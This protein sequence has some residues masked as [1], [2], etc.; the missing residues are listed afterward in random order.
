MAIKRHKRGG[1]VYLA[2]YKSVRVGKKVISKFIRYIGP[3]DKQNDIDK[4][5]KKVLDRLQL[6]RSYR[7]GDVR[8][9][10]SIAKD[11]G[12][13]EIIDS[14][15]CSK[16]S[17]EGPSP[18][19]LLTAW[20]INR[21]IDPESATKLER[22]IPTTELPILLDLPE[23]VFTK[24]AF[25][26]A[27]DFVCSKSEDVDLILDQTPELDKS[28]YEKWRKY[29]PLSD[30]QRE[31]I[32]YDMTTLLF[33]G[34][35]CPL[36]ELGYN[37]DRIR[38][39]QVNLALLVSGWDKF[40][41]MHFVYEG[42]RHS[43]STVKNLLSSLSRST[44]E[45]GTLIWDRGN[46]SLK[47]VE[48]VEESGWKLIT[49]VPKTSKEAKEIIAE[50][51][52]RIGPDSLVRSS[53]AGHIYAEKNVQS[54]YGKMRSTFVY[55]NRERGVKDSDA[56]NEALQ[57]IGLDLDSLAE[58]GAHWP[59]KRLHSKIQSIVG[60]WSDYVDVIVSR[61]SDEPRIR[62]SYRKQELRQ[63]EKQDGK[64][65]ILST[66]DSINAQKAV[67]AYLE[68]DFIEK[69]FRV[70]KTQ[71]ENQ[72]VRHRLENR[73]KAY[74]FVCMLAYR[75]LAVLQWRLKQA[76]NAE[77]AWESAYAL[78]QDLSRVEKADVK[79][80]NE[81]RTL[82]LNISAHT[83]KILKD[84]GMIGLFKEETKLAMEGAM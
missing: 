83:S 6:N 22:W 12:F 52:I 27:L 54:L 61:K 2:E 75:L 40:P 44:I 11:L 14:V 24:D 30:G 56:R 37:P 50:T 15:C 53:R 68:K 69:V 67:N 23:S 1:R 63:A 60:Q 3:E 9:L 58:T 43:A 38:R 29:N 71:E 35:S 7:A 13:C 51:E 26:N 70:I 59:E 5:K 46:V 20:A 49:G 84:I 19:K 55:Q 80:G 81:I 48:M 73:V 65:L 25:L 39:L 16:S 36:A 57:I 21:A 47:H 8:V 41:L 33:F 31:T 72:P 78:L 62:W 77:D 66:D 34:I 74:I 76:S 64:W 17:F 32:A 82:F 45:P 4:P 10:W 79:F 42:S 18:G 28:L